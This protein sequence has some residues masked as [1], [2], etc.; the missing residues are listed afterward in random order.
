MITR[1]TVHLVNIVVTYRH[2]VDEENNE[3]NEEEDAD[4]TDEVP[5]VLLPDDV[6]QGLP[7]RGEPQEG[8]LRAAEKSRNITVKIYR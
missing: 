7:G 2:R 1:V 5:L 3:G 4:A 8:G 6:F